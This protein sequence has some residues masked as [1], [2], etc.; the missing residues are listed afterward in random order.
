MR[1]RFVAAG[2][3][4]CRLAHLHQLRCQRRAQALQFI[5]LLLLAVDR[6]A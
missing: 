6:L 2:S 1:R 4:T 3:R 5:D